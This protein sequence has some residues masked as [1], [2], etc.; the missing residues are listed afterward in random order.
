MPKN[1]LKDVLEVILSAKG[2]IQNTLSK[3]NPRDVWSILSDNNFEL[4]YKI[5]DQY[6]LPQINGSLPSDTATSNLEAALNTCR[7]RNDQLNFI[8]EICSSGTGSDPRYDGIRQ[9]IVDRITDPSSL[10]D[11]LET[12]LSVKGTIQNTLSKQEPNYVW[13][14]LSNNNFELFY[15]ILDQ[16]VLSQIN[17]SL[18]NDTA[19]SNLEAALNTC[20]ERN[21][22]LNFITAI[23][24][25]KGSDPRYDGK[26]SDPRYDGIRPVIVDIITD[27]MEERDPKKVSTS[28][29]EGDQNPRKVLTLM[30]AAALAAAKPAQK[31][32]G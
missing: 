10:K 23:C 6:V 5:L 20:R 12:I 31:V 25:E 13:S 28:K 21:N 26:G 1:S 19:T 30:K 24:S 16:Y 14:I 29:K 2:T 18:P 3:Q 9:V 17:G 8:A 22:Q 7:E 11:V 32:Q 27:L 4:F 15:K